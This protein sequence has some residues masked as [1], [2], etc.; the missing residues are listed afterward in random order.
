MF[1]LGFRE[2]VAMDK[3]S[4]AERPQEQKPDA[5]VADHGDGGAELCLRVLGLRSPDLDLP[6]LR[7]CGYL[8]WA[9]L[10]SS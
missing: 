1:L 10:H 7:S 9:V 3:T 5:G 4:F 2:R 6:L 8:L